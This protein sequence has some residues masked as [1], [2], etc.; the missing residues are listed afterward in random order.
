MGNS[1]GFKKSYR[2]KKRT[3]FIKKASFWRNIGIFVITAIICYILFFSP[4]F[5]I[6]SVIISGNRE[7]SSTKLE[8]Y[9]KKQVENTKLIVRTKNLLVIGTNNIE[10]S[11][12]REFPQI[13]TVKVSRK[14]PHSLVVQVSERSP[15]FIFSKPPG[16]SF[17]L[18]D[19]GVV[20][21]KITESPEIKIPEI[22]NKN[23]TGNI[24]LGE[25]PIND[26]LL[27]QIKA[28]RDGIEGNLKIEIKKIF[29]VSDE[30]IDIQTWEKW[31][32][33][34]SLKDPIEGQIFNLEQILA[35]QITPE[36]KLKLEYVDLRFGSKV[37][38]K[39]Q[40]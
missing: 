4:V 33:Y 24:N 26:K 35:K 36:Q 2:F 20:F 7:V 22:E 30:R 39:V 40:Q 14:F 17:F 16:E 12:L 8:A 38:Y 28:I 29:I 1:L 13:D 37:Y 18:D 10:N 27:M 11:V 23:F 15:A 34:F 9:L 3:P 25:K 21:K 31:Y 5:K 32:V 6:N 19:N